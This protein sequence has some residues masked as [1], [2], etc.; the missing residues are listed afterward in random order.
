MATYV[1]VHGGGHGGWCYQRLTPLLRDAGHDVYTP[2]LTGLG[3]RVHL[4]DE[5]VDLDVHITDV[6]N[7]LRYEGLTDVILVGHS[8]GGLV[9]TGAADR[10]ADR[11]GHLVYMDAPIPMNGESLATLM[12]SIMRSVR[13]VGR[14]VDGVEV[15]LWPGPDAGRRFGVTDDADVAWM[16]DKL[17]PHPW[18]SF[19][20]PLRLQDEG[21][22]KQ[23]PRAV[24]MNT[25]RREPPEDLPDAEFVA[26]RAARARE[27]QR[28]FEI[29]TGHDMMITEPRLIADMLLQ[30]AS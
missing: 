8:Y 21:A 14:V 4:L 12:P 29:N 24:I 19:T 1:L 23:I 17:A 6:V 27:A 2:T 18:K 10:A 25:R 30:L 9:V 3:E 5:H 13:T 28:I 15:V 7:V 22:L 20:Q 16:Q 26:E 11:V